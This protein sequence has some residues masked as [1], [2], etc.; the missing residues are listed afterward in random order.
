M[1]SGAGSRPMDR[2]QVGLV[3]AS[4]MVAICQLWEGSHAERAAVRETHA[5]GDKR[6]LMDRMCQRICSERSRGENILIWSGRWMHAQSLGAM[7][8]ERIGY[9]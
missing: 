3:Q 4:W 6:G 7:G 9:P 5:R 1:A 8:V 2:H